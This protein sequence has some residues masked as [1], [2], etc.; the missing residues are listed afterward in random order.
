MGDETK[1]T[2]TNGGEGA[3]N[4]PRGK[5]HTIPDGSFKSIKDNLLRRTDE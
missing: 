2:E 3:G 5:T 4:T 1:P